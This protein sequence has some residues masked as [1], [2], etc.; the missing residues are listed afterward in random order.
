MIDALQPVQ[1]Q[2]TLP[3]LPLQFVPLKGAKAAESFASIYAGLVKQEEMVD[4]TQAPQIDYAKYIDGMKKKVEYEIK[5][6]QL[7]GSPFAMMFAGL[8][9]SLQS[10][11]NIEFKTNRLIKGFAKGTVSPEEVTIATSQ[12]NVAMTMTT[13]VLSSASQT[14]KEITSIQI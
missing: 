8:V 3:G 4:K 13:T 2:V 9:S 6:D 12:L 10:V 7:S 11:S 1:Q 5:Q 14:L